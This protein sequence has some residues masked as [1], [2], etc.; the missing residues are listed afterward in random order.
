MSTLYD[1]AAPAKLNLFLHV[2][3]RRDDGY[4]LLQSV[5]ALIDW[6]DT[7]HLETRPHGAISRH[8]LTVALPSDD[9][10]TKAA[11]ALQQATGCPLGVHITLRKDIPSEAGLGGGSSDAATC[12]LGLNRLW[13]LGLG[14]ADLARLGAQLGADIPFFIGGQNAWVEGVGE[15]L[16]PLALPAAQ[17]VVLKPPTGLATQ[18]IFQSELLKRDTK[19][20]TILGF[21]ADA[22][23]PFGFGCND[24][25]GVATTLC[26]EVATAL[27]LLENVGLAGRMTGSG[28]AVFAPLPPATLGAQAQSV[29]QILALQK[30]LGLV[31]NGRH[32][33]MRLCKGLD[34]H[35]L[36]D[37]VS[38]A[39]H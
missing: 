34:Q 26:P 19:P 6:Q 16:T 8:D 3:G 32:W 27:Q 36:F 24:L 17:F 13:N 37:W 31:P 35:P 21:T 29:N 25:Q 18:G 20:A 39:G 4:H 9:L 1:L 15:Q 23:T 22:R 5:F 11:R 2:V 7:L 10:C 33:Q 12:L 30:A 38:E 14:R 28:S